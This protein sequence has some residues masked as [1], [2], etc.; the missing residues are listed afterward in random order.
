MSACFFLVCPLSS[1]R[2]RVWQKGYNK[3]GMIYLSLSSGGA[4][5]RAGSTLRG[6]IVLPWM[7]GRYMTIRAMNPQWLNGEKNNDTA[8]VKYRQG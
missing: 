6:A 3:V 4:I 7:P 2:L 1:W 8:G 5:L